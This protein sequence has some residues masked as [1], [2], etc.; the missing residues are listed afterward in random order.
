MKKLSCLG[1]R[2]IEVTHS[3]LPQIVGVAATMILCAGVFASLNSM[4]IAAPVH[5][6]FLITA[7][8]SIGKQ[9]E[10]KLEQG[11]G[12]IK[13]KVGEITGPSQGAAEEIKGKAKEDA[14]KVQGSLEKS[15]SK[16]E[17]R[18]SRETYKDQNVINK[19]GKKLNEATEKGTNAVKSWFSS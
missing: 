15:R 9:V 5:Q 19:A 10:G 11:S 18:W 3:A 12:T 1:N 17:N 13:R 4:A 16:I 14:G 8:S 7:G 6:S 2:L